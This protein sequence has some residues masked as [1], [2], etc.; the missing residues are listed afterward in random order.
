ML[1][2]YGHPFQIERI[3]PCPKCNAIFRESNVSSVE[4]QGLNGVEWMPTNC[5]DE[6]SKPF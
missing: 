5:T 2:V 1:L 4:L 3:V 6:I